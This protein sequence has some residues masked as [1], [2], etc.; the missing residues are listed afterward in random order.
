MASFSCFARPG[1]TSD[2]TE[3]VINFFRRNESFLNLSIA[4]S[5]LPVTHENPFENKFVNISSNIHV[6]LNLPT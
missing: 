2:L 5:I 1:F 6:G 3:T 4:T